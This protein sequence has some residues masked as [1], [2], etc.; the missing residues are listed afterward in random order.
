MKTYTINTK[1]FQDTI[2]IIRD[3]A[4][5]KLWHTMDGKEYLLNI[6]DSDTYDDQFIEKYALQF[7]YNFY[8]LEQIE[9]I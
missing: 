9:I 3:G 4:D 6:F 1:G 5:I 8:D 2:D 7:I